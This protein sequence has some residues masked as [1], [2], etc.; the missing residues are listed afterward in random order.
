M[1][2]GEKV[3]ALRES[4]GWSRERLAGLSREPLAWIIDVEE[5]RVRPHKKG[6]PLF[7]LAYTFDVDMEELWD[8]NDD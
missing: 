7:E 1:T 3:R 5:G 6:R 4:R 2:T 8:D